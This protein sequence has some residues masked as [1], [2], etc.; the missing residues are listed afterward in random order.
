MLHKESATQAPRGVHWMKAAAVK[1]W[2]EIAQVSGCCFG[3]SEWVA[4]DHP[5]LTSGTDQ[6]RP[7]TD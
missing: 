5:F 3:N 7:G 1:V 4:N 2:T 6:L